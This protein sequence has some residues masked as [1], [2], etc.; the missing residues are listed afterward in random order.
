LLRSKG[1]RTVFVFSKDWKTNKDNCKTY[2]LEA[3][4]GKREFEHTESLQMYLQKLSKI[5]LSIPDNDLRYFYILES[6][7]KFVEFTIDGL[8]LISKKGIID[9]KAKK[10]IV[11]FE[12]ETKLQKFLQRKLNAL[13]KLGFERIFI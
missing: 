7:S 6:Q 1:W 9:K 13:E 10:E 4:N 8:Q 2:I 12:N 3:I 5:P 11:A